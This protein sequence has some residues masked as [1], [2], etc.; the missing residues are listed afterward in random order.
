MA[1]FNN[2]NYPNFCGQCGNRINASVGNFC[3]ICGTPLRPQYQQPQYQQPQY[4]P[5]QQPQQLP[6]QQSRR[7]P[8]PTITTTYITPFGIGT[9]VV[10]R[11]G[12]GC[13]FVSTAGATP[14][15]YLKRMGNEKIYIPESPD[16]NL[17]GEIKLKLLS[18][19]CRSRDVIVVIP[20]EPNI[21]QSKSY[22]ADD[23]H[24]I[25]TKHPNAPIN[26]YIVYIG[27]NKYFADQ[28]IVNFVKQSLPYSE[29]SFTNFFYDTT[30]HNV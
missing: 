30:I 25:Q 10:P 29:L 2:N 7:T 22:V 5:P 9:T 18:A 19:I 8:T 24:Y 27:N 26:V 17:S 13:N 23:L 15:K 6:Y 28:N 11:Y 20:Y 1:N 3:S 16:C 4:Q 14:L 21:A 12:H